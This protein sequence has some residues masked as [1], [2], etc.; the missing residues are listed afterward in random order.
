[1]FVEFIIIWKHISTLNQI[2]VPSKEHVGECISERK[3]PK[4][5]Y[6]EA[7]TTGM[8]RPP[9]NGYNYVNVAK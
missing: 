1:M 2:S 8:V 7:L 3:Y 4:I 6:V 9:S 5:T